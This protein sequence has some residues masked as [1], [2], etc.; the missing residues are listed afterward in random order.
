MDEVAEE[1][2]W[3]EAGLEERGSMVGERKAA[4]QGMVGPAYSWIFPPSTRFFLVCSC[5]IWEQQTW[6]SSSIWPPCALFFL[7]DAA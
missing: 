4:V 7:Q 5:F 1:Q 6:V 3:W 2:G